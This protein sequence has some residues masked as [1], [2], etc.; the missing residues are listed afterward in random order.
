MA[1]HSHQTKSVPLWAPSALRQTVNHMWLIAIK[2]MQLESNAH[3]QLVAWRK[4]FSPQFDLQGCAVL[5]RSCSSRYLVSILVNSRMRTQLEHS[6]E[7]NQKL[8]AHWLE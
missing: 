1:P 8:P 3:L 2:M 7:Q 6:R 4:P 5:R